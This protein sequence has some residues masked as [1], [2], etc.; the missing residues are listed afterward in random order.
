MA[1]HVL[2]WFFVILCIVSSTNI[3]LL[4]LKNLNYK[5][6]NIEYYHHNFMTL[7]KETKW[8]PVKKEVPLRPKNLLFTDLLE[9]RFIGFQ[10][11]KDK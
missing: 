4:K 8:L 10:S 6:N 11:F 2:S 1:D 9:D 7:I 3:I 5:Y